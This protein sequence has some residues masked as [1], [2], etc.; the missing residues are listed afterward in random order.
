[1]ASDGRE[2]SAF[3]QLTRRNLIK[4][5]TLA[6]AA[7]GIAAAEPSGIGAAPA[8][9]ALPLAAPPEL[10]C[11]VSIEGQKQGKFAGDFN[12]AGELGPIIGLA[13]FHGIKSPR[14]SASGQATG[15]RQHDPVR[16]VKRWGPATPQLSQA[17]ATNETLKTVLFEFGGPGPRGDFAVNFTVQLANARV[18]GIEQ[19][20]EAGTTLEEI[21]FVYQKITWTHAPSGNT[22][23]DSS[24]TADN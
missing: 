9:Q 3:L 14:D 21:S 24:K 12:D 17:L 2:P 8:A 20:A 16:F 1:M 11:L 7:F 6:T 19:H 22:A 23:E 15:K 10:T 4:A 5:G 18:S 13:Y